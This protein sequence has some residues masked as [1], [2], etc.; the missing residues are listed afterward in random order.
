MTGST[1]ADIMHAILEL[2][3]QN[4]TIDLPYINIVDTEHPERNGEF[5]VNRIL[6]IV[7]A[8]WKRNGWHMMRAVTLLDVDKFEAFLPDCERFPGWLLL[9]GRLIMIK[10]PSTSN[11]MLD[12]DKMNGVK[13]L[14][15]SVTYRKHEET[16]TAI[17]ADI[18]RSESYTLMVFPQGTKLDN[19]IFGDNK[20]DVETNKTIIKVE[21]DQFDNMYKK[22][23]NSAVLHW[24]FA[25]EGGTRIRKGK[26]KADRSQAL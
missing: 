23:I 17:N 25:E 19:K 5:Q 22:T 4:G 8:N 18:N 12:V 13:G 2:Y 11:W 9:K 3:N 20:T 21:K 10:H 24:R 7:H 14:D 16:R 1:M 15:C 26:K 6:E